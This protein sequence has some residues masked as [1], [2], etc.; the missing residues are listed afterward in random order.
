M[1]G[2]NSGWLYAANN[3]QD[4]PGGQSRCFVVRLL[5]GVLANLA[6][7]SS[8]LTVVPANAAANSWAASKAS[9]SVLSSEQNS[10]SAEPFP[11]S[12]TMHFSPQELNVKAA[13]KAAANKLVFFINAFFW[14]KHQSAGP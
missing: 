9:R 4:R 6:Y 7:F 13:N 10:A 3:K 11:Y 14:G 2:G 1:E 12:Q 8:Q 5:S